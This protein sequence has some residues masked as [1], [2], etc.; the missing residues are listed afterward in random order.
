MPSIVEFDSRMTGTCKALQN[1]GSRYITVTG[2]FSLLQGYDLAVD[3]RILSGVNRLEE[4]ALYV[5][6]L[7]HH[8]SL[9]ATTF[10][11]MSLSYGNLHGRLLFALT[12]Q[13]NLY[14]ITHT[15]TKQ[16]TGSATM[17]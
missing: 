8:S 9:T 15:L 12:I 14:Y 6:A 10:S 1:G 11:E 16:D 7:A 13:S 4:L 17:Q 2:E 5:D 3:P